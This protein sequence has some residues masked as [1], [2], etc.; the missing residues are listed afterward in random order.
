MSG[1]SKWATIK[2]KKAATDA[3][4][5]ALFT[6]TIKNI[7][8]AARQGKD[9]ETNSSLRTAI[10]Q[11]RAA[12]VPKDKIENAILKGSGELPGVSYEEIIYEGYGPGGAA[13]IIECVTDN[14]NRTVSDV[15][16][17]LTKSGG[18]IGGSG[19]VMYMFKQK[20][21]IRVSKEDLGGHSSDDVEL[22]AIEADAEDV[23]NEEEGLTIITARE[24]LNDTIDE[25]EKNEIPVASSGVE[26][27]TDNI[28]ELSEAD[29]AKLTIV[30]EQLEDNDDVN[31]VYT[32]T[33]I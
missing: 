32:N 4:R 19:S 20:G 22:L 27:I 10:T 5:G 9:P 8:V 1:H 29:V 13:L 16:S 14:T 30:V 28:M 17:V 18:S 26:F 2:R 21:V 15:R 6:R 23:Q 33:D 12:N 7:S 31:N 25:F 24:K 11:A 3:K